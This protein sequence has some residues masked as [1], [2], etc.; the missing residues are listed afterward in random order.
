[1]LSVTEPPNNLSYVSPVSA[2]VGPALAP[3]SPRISGTVDHYT[4]SPTL[5][6]G[7]VLNSISGV[8]SGTPSEARNL[9]PYTITAS[10]LAG[11]TRFVLLLTVMP[12][13]SGATPRR[14]RPLRPL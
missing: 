5:P 1:M 4:V 8:L 6:A 9:A 12:A 10:S 7:I 11:S 13:P 2:T 3:R 14:V